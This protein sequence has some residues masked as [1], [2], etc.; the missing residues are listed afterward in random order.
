M[1]RNDKVNDKSENWTAFKDEITCQHCPAVF[2]IE[3]RNV[4]S[5]IK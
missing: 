5:P 3:K 4:S 2:E 1:F